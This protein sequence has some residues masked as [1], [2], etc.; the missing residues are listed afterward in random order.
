MPDS[1]KLTQEL[2]TSFIKIISNG[3]VIFAWDEELADHLINEL[4]EKN[5]VFVDTDQTLIGDT[6]YLIN[7]SH[8]QQDMVD[9]KRI[10]PLAR[11]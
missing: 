1:A 9:R 7:L 10:I 11:Q 5:L 3:G 4:I 2:R 8:I 6:P